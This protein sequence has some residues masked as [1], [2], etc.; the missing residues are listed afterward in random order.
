VA[1]TDTIAGY[2]NNNDKLHAVSGAAS[3]TTNATISSPA[4]TYV[5]TV[6]LGTLRAANYIL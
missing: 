3:L 6:A 5:I 2:V 1:A 4:G